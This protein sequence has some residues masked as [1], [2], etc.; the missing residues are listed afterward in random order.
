MRRVDTVRV[1]YPGHD[2]AGDIAGSLEGEDFGVFSLHTQ[3]RYNFIVSDHFADPF[4]FNGR[5]VTI[6]A[7]NPNVRH[8]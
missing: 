8:S 7:T 1:R 4:Q 6:L 3:R 5:I 2:K